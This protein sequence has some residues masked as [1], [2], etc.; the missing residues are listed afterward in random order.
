MPP[1]PNI[2]D[3]I[4]KLLRLADTSRGA[5]EHEAET[6]LAKAE[7]LMTRHKIDSAMLR[8]AHGSEDLP[9]IAVQKEFINLP[10]TINPA[11]ML[12][13]S[14]LQNHFGVRI[15]L[16]KK[17][18]TTPVDI[19]GTWEDV[20]FAV[21]V[22]HFLRKT[23]SRCWKEF[24]ATGSFPDRKS[25]YR[26]LHDGLRAAIVEGKKRAE[27]AASTEERSQYQMVLVD[28][29]AAIER[30]MSAQYGQLRQRRSRSTR[31]NSESYQAGKAKG[32]RIEINRALPGGAG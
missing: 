18:Q 15:V 22:F 17:P 30:Y 2:L 11:D 25:Y 23:F 19:I 13:L 1:P 31:V 8:M 29:T 26:G 28:T 4:Q 9:G 21:H 7:E 6:A 27:S 10:K 32:G 14:L 20:Q 16:F 24:K 5:S 12:I 3:L